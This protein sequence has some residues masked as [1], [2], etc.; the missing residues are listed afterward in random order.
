MDRIRSLGE[1]FRSCLSLSAATNKLM[2]RLSRSHKSAD[3]K[4]ISTGA[5]FGGDN[6]T[7]IPDSFSN[8]NVQDASV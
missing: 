6:A 1:S 2:Q 4:P 8:M 5:T 3:H 7:G